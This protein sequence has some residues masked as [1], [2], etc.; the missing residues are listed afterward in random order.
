MFG[1]CCR[2]LL[3]IV[4][5]VLCVSGAYPLYARELESFGVNPTRPIV[6]DRENCEVRI[7]AQLQPKAFS[8]S[9]FGGT[10]GYHAVV[11]KGGKAAKEALLVSDADDSSLYEAMVSL[12]ASPGNNLTISV[13]KE[14]NNPKSPAPDTRVEGT[15]VQALVWWQ[16]LASPVPLESMLHDA[17]GRGL[18]MRFG[19]NKAL[20]P[21]WKSGCIACL[22]SCPGGKVSN[23]SY[24]I[25]DYVEHPQNFSVN[26]AQVPEG[27]RQAVVI[28]RP[29][30]QEQR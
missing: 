23:R 25:R 1:A 20:I 7:S 10:P 19:G 16:G 28:F 9:W 6:V 15:P 21:Q 4:L 30:I 12:G 22:Y 27:R 24:T 18:D 11:W 14:R 5:G 29:L 2:I 26:S 17:R 3:G 13:W 8:G